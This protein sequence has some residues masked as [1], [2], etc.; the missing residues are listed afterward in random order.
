[1]VAQKWLGLT[2]AKGCSREMT[3]YVDSAIRD[4]DIPVRHNDTW[5]RALPN[6]SI[7]HSF[8]LTLFFFS[9]VTKLGPIVIKI[10]FFNCMIMVVLSIKLKVDSEADWVEKVHDSG[11]VGCIVC[12]CFMHRFTSLGSTDT[13]STVT[14]NETVTSS[15]STFKSLIFLEA[16]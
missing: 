4:G 15:S 16:L 6:F 12:H 8:I 5:V 7:Y 2:H 3:G 11:L 10:Y 1:M 14:S 13:K 9:R